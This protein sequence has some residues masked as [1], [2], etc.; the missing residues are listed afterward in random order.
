MSGRYWLLLSRLNIAIVTI[1]GLHTCIASVYFR[2]N[3]KN[4]VYADCDKLNLD[5]FITLIII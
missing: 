3:D 5:N 2:Y 4:I 1:S